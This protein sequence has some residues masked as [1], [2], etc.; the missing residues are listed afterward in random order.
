MQKENSYC[1]PLRSKFRD[2]GGTLLAFSLNAFPK[3]SSGLRGSRNIPLCKAGGRASLE[4][5]LLQRIVALRS[6]FPE[7]GRVA[8]GAGQTQSTAVSKRPKIWSRLPPPPDHEIDLKNHKILFVWL[9]GWEPAGATCLSFSLPPGGLQRSELRLS[10]SRYV[11]VSERTGCCTLHPAIRKAV[12]RLGPEEV[13][14]WRNTGTL[15]KNRAEGFSRKEGLVPHLIQTL[16]S[17]TTIVQRGTE[18]ILPGSRGSLMG[19]TS[20]E[21]TGNNLQLP[22]EDHTEDLGQH[23]RNF[24]KSLGQSNSCQSVENQLHRARVR[25]WDSGICST[26]RLLAVSTVILIAQNL[27]GKDKIMTPINYT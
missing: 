27:A 14:D 21:T 4:P 26:N 15:K 9:L 20:C 2:A 24:S 5:E 12:P 1:F 18:N 13:M 22:Q 17:R 16:L 7:P 6:D 19:T 23:T 10:T 8:L 11:P 25:D 3:A